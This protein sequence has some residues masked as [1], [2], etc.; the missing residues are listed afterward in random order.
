[1]RLLFG[2]KGLTWRSAIIPSLMPKPDYTPLTGGYR[3]TPS[4]QIGADV[5]CDTQIILA[6][7]ERRWPTP[8]AVRGGLDWAINLWA[9]RQFFGATVPIIFGEYG[10]KVGDDFIKDREA[11]S[12][13][14]FDVAAMKAATGPMKGQWRGQAAWLE[15]QLAATGTGWLAGDTA[16]LADIAAYM[17]VWF[18]GSFLPGSVEA[19]TPGMPLIG[20]W[21]ARV[22][23]IGH[24]DRHE[25]DPRDAL[26]IAKAA[27][28]AGS[29]TH[30]AADPL[31]LSPGDKVV[32]HGRRLRPRPRLRPAGRR[33]APLDHPGAGRPAGGYGTRPLPAR[34]LLRG[35][36]LG[37]LPGRHAH[38][39]LLAMT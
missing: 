34:G 18:L 16:G 13:R 21:A 14:P 32:V 23:A 39:A 28:P 2:L 29:L 24:G 36:W 12:G 38:A 9:D 22:K 8:P 6:E 10:D 20:D 30:D 1:M 15:D 7:V 33:H 4:L 27:A 11:M 31:G 26:A 25:I 17:N 37:A 35:P 3:R 5:Y 19:L